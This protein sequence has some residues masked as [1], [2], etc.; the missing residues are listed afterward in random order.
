MTDSE[1]RQARAR[2]L[3]VAGIPVRNAWQLLLYAWDL[4]A[5]GDRFRAASETSPTLLALL[6][7]V[8]LDTLEPRVPG[9][10]QRRHRTERAVVAGLRGKLDLPA[11]LARQ[12]LLLGRTVCI[13]PVL[14]LDTPL[15]RIY[16]GTL[17]RLAGALRREAGGSAAPAAVRILAERAAR[18]EAALT[19]VRLGP[20]RPGDFALLALG[21]NDRADALPLAICRLLS[22]AHLPTETQGDR[23][24]RALL[25][26]R[27]RFR[28]LF[29]RFV[30][31]FLRSRLPTHAVRAERLAWPDE[32]HSPFVPGMLTD[33]T[34]TERAPPHRRL[35]ID[36]KFMGGL[37][38]VGRHGGHRLREAHLYQLYA[39]LQTQ[40]ARGP[41]FASAAGL[42]LYPRAG[43]AGDD[44]APDVSEVSMRVQ[45]HALQAATLDLA[46][47][48]PEVEARLL[49]LVAAVFPPPP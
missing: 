22:E 33:V 13:V 48:W 39:Y 15:N 12:S 4:A 37:L 30:R 9:G 18:L 42:L 32:L 31:N 40:S 11:T 14:T 47:P 19:P 27:V 38:A 34:L 1:A 45:G 28:T 20:V 29:E 49:A 6:A 5:L 21:R 44:D 35:T 25:R 23:L 24:V 17:H 10:L 46:A 7:Q 43:S 41:E 8:L 16:R 2:G 26:D 36:A 3:G